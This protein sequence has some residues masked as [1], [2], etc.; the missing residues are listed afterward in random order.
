M[1]TLSDL[2]VDR[3]VPWAICHTFDKDPTNTEELVNE[4]KL[5]WTVSHHDIYTDL[6]NPI[7][8]TKAVYRDDT[9]YCFGIIQKPTPVI[10]QNTDAFSIF[11]HFIKNASLTAQTGGGFGN[12]KVFTC[13]KIPNSYKVLDDDVEHYFVVVN[14]HLKPDG[15]ITVLNTPVR[16]VCQNTLQQALSSNTCK[17]R[18]DAHFEDDVVLKNISERVLAS[19]ARAVDQLTTKAEAMVKVKTNQEYIEKLLDNM[20]PY[21]VINS[22][23]DSETIDKHEI[24]NATTSMIRKTFVEKC[25]DADDLQN[26]KGTEYALFNALVDFNQ[27][28]FKKSDDMVDVKKRMGSM[29]GGL[30]AKYSNFKKMNKG[31]LAA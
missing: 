11:D 18:I 29:S 10:T 8:D 31:L 30:V 20:F 21:I 19:S 4:C 23:E 9:N 22:S 16:V 25:L 15:K 27:H 28:Y 17:I 14:D 2:V 7:P 24:A 13:F 3:Q 6:Q 5:N 12:G 26:Y 1:A